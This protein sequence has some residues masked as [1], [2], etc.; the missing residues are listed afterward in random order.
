MKYFCTFYTAVKLVVLFSH[1]RNVIPINQALFLHV[2]PS[3]R[4]SY[5]LLGYACKNPQDA[6]IIIEKWTY[7]S[8]FETIFQDMECTRFFDLTSCRL[9]KV[10]VRDLVTHY[11]LTL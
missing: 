11:F 3:S 1:V 10:Q 7:L 9:W 8:Y 5:L 4:Y 6:M 2:L